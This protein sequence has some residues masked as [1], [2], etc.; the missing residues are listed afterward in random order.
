MDGSLKEM[1][2]R[3]D[4]GRV[5]GCLG[6]LTGSIYTVHLIHMRRMCWRETLSHPVQCLPG[7]GVA[8][9]G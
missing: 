7:S 9:L 8:G 5:L 2:G 3:N 6:Y 1:Q 4:V